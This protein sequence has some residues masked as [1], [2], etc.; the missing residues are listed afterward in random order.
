MTMLNAN[1][2]TEFVFQAAR[3][4]GSFFGLISQATSEFS[5]LIRRGSV[6][7][8]VNSAILRIAIF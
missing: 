4:A 8:K 2:D 5:I 7:R 3:I 1:I 6:V